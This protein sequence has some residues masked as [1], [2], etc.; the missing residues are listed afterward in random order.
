V[1]ALPLA[2]VGGTRGETGVALAA[3]GFLAVVLGSK[4]F[5]GGFDDTTT[6]AKD[7][8]KSGLLLDVVITQ[9][10]AIFELLSGENQTLLVR[11]NAFLVLDF[12][13]HVVDGVRRLHLQGD[14]LAS[15]GLDKDLHAS[16]E[17]EDKVKGRLLLNVVIREGATVLK[18]FPREDQTL[19]IGRDAFLVL[20]LGLDVVDCVGGLDL[21]GDGLAREGFDED[22]HGG[23]V[24]CDYNLMRRC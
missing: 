6:K 22:L 14:G 1:T 4:S 12:R 11:R 5:Q 2:A 24:C 10:T 19:L 8:V 21:E 15:Q 17:T 20:D 3:D 13:L 7:K 9:S 23:R 16:T 18:L